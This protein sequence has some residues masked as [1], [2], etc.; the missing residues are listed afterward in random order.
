M[1]VTD[2][3]LFR[4][5]L[6]EKGE[7]VSEIEYTKNNYDEDSNLINAGLPTITTNYCEIGLYDQKIYFVFIIKSKT[8]NKALFNYIKDQPGVQ[9]YG[10]VDFKTTLFPKSDFDYKKFIDLINKDKYL[11]IQF[12]TKE[13]KVK[14]LFILYSKLTS[15]FDK[16]KVVVVNQIKVDLTKI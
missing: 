11:Q 2:L 5:L 15:V 12:N 4:K 13:I 3:N 10:F 16:S 9:I 6:I 8:F 7:P 14:N 1:N